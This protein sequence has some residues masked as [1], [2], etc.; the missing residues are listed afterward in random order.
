MME[1]SKRSAN[2]IRF[3]EHFIIGACAKHKKENKEKKW[4]AH[5]V[6]THKIE[7]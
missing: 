4:Y 7:N 3:A 1:Q 2:N 5:A 6:K